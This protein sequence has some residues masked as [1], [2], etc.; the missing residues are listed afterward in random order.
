MKR[1]R[2]VPNECFFVPTVARLSACVTRPNILMKADLNAMVREVCSRGYRG[3]IGVDESGAG[4]LA[5]PLVCAAVRLDLSDKDADIDLMLPYLNDSKKVTPARRARIYS[6]IINNTPPCIGYDVHVTSAREVDELNILQAR[7]LGLAAVASAIAEDGDYLFVDG[8]FTI[9]L[10]LDNN[11]NIEQEAVVGG[12]GLI[13]VVAAASVVAK[14][15]RD[16][17]MNQLH[18]EY[19]VYGF[20]KHKAYA[21]KVHKVNLEKY[22]PCNIHRRSYRP[23]RAAE[24]LAK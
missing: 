19:P 14:E 17:L 2:D 1:R 18:L 4:A 13:S 24:A 9:N 16:E 8:N 21:T 7:K 12:D 23:V 22:G 3:V 11:N 6:S 10:D 15:Y 20:D 5:G